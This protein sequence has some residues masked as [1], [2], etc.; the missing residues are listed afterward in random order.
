MRIFRSCSLTFIRNVFHAAGSQQYTTLEQAKKKILIKYLSKPFFPTNKKKPDVS[1]YLTYYWFSGMMFQCTM[2][3]PFFFGPAA[4]SG[5]RVLNSVVYRLTTFRYILNLILLS[6]DYVLRQAKQEKKNH[7]TYEE[8]ENALPACNMHHSFIVIIKFHKHR[9]IF[10]TIPQI[11]YKD[12]LHCDG[13]IFSPLSTTKFE[14]YLEGTRSSVFVFDGLSLSY[15]CSQFSHVLRCS[16]CNT[17]F[18][19]HF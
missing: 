12:A 15:V 3:F 17:N 11:T 16:R 2:D 9:S 1:F 19:D 18:S 6:F 8:H 10:Q 7:T 4:R 14:C 13:T 5:K